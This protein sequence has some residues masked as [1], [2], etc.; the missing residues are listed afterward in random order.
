MRKVLYNFRLFDGLSDTL[1]DGK[2]ITID[3]NRIERVGEREALVA[4]AALA[5]DGSEPVDMQGYTL[6]PG[7]ID[8]H[9]HIT[10]P[11]M[12]DFKDK[13][14]RTAV[15]RQ[16]ELNF[17]SCMRY[18]ITTV[19]DMG[20]FPGSIQKWR[21][22]IDAGE[23]IGPRIFTPNSFITSAD[24]PPERA[25]V[26][27]APAAWIMGGQLVARVKSPRQVR[28][29]A[30]RNLAAGA[31][32][33]KTQYAENSMFFQGKLATLSD[34]CFAEL[35]KIAREMGVRTAL[36]HTENAGFRKGIQ[37]DFDCLEHCSLERLDEA[38][39]E[40]FVAKGMA[41][42]PTLRVNRSGFELDESLEWVR[43]GGREDFD[44]VAAAQIE[45]S[46]EACMRVPYPPDDRNA[47]LDVEMSRRGF[48]NTM[49]NTQR[50]LAAGA[51]IGAG[52]DCFGC[53]LNLPGFFWKE[54]SLLSQAGLGNAGALKTATIVNASILGREAEI[55]SI[56]PGKRADI[57]AIEGDPIADIANVKNV[58]M[59]IKDGLP[60]ADCRRTDWH[61]P[62]RTKKGGG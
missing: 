61:G 62:D 7:F 49:M 2:A 1:R 32:F 41:I 21:R 34:E 40:R 58:R 38:D 54:L 30:L 5:K 35:R 57:V 53:Y 33:L 47:Y 56:E 15:D 52:S 18:G 29:A 44:P 13:A 23:A 51:R 20:A 36:H 24:G 16:R 17:R 48:E 4:E 25:P 27:P 43:G 37:F 59:V 55:G 28:K 9:V 11:M 60:Y 3:G 50:L 26:L 10:A 39:I 42:V 12:T 31:D 8:L 14:A 6:L 19:R 22:R 46:I 45:R